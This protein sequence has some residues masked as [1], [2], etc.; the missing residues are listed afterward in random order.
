ML[1]AFLCRAEQP[2][3]DFS[4]ST[5]NSASALFLHQVEQYQKINGIHNHVSVT[6]LSQ[7][8]LL[9]LFTRQELPTHHEW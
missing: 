9:P 1:A 2:K 5:F 7:D 3:T 8:T 4:A 6:L